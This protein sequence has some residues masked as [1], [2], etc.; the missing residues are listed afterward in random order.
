MIDPHGHEP[1]SVLLA[2]AEFPCAVGKW[3]ISTP[4]Q[5]N[6]RN[7]NATIV[8]NITPLATHRRPIP[9]ME[10]DREDQPHHQGTHHL[11]IS[12]AR[13][14]FTSAARG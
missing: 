4:T 12:P 3:R 13:Q 7:P 2:V 1:H 9:S 14:P 8:S 5:V 10:Q 11:G 6:T